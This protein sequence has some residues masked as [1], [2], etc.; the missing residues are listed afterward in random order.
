MNALESKLLRIFPA[1]LYTLASLTITLSNMFGG[2]DPINMRPVV[3][4]ADADWHGLG[5]SV[6]EELDT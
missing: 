3:R 2:G 5:A 1:K 4:H 6:I